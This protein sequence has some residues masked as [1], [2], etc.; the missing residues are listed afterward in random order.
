MTAVL[1]FFA[2]WVVGFVVCALLSAR[3][4]YEDEQATPRWQRRV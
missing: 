1:G 4:R 2:G 3:T